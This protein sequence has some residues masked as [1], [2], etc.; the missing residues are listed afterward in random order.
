MSEPDCNDFQS[1]MLESNRLQTFKNWPNPN[2]TPTTLAK[3]GF[4][5]L[6]RS[7]QVKCAWCKGV[8]AKWELNDNAFVEHQR[9][10]PDC[11]L[12]QEL[13]IQQLLV[14]K[15]PNMST[16][17]ARL[18]TYD[19]WPISD[20]Q[21]PEQLAQAGLYYQNVDDQVRCFYCNIGLRSWQKV[22]YF[23]L[24]NQSLFF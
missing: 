7:D 15:K 11:P 8:I 10:F 22:C 2:I 23:I 13:G 6:N 16:L 4:F 14:P 18:R 17:E 12:I 1:M 24:Y 5:Y 3:A 19:N 9:F 21:N 20:I